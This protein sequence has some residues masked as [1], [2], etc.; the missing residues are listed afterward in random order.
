MIQP[1]TASNSRLLPVPEAA[2]RLGL[3]PATLKD[4]IY[5]RRI[6]YVRV[7]RAVRIAENTITDI[8]AR[9]TAPAWE[10]QR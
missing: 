7:G 5:R 4:W 2:E 9:G 10:G 1:H 8:I 3:R 6:E